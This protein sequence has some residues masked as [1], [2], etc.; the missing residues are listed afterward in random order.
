MKKDIRDLKARIKG[1]FERHDDQAQVVIELYRMVFPDWD[2][3]KEIKGHP[4]TGDQLWEFN[5]TK[6]KRRANMVRKGAC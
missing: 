1:F 4:E 5:Y 3:I 2:R 6:G